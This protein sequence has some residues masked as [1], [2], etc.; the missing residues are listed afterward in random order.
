MPAS[1]DICERFWNLPSKPGEEA[2]RERLFLDDVI[3]KARLDREIASRRRGSEKSKSKMGLVVQRW[4]NALSRGQAFEDNGAVIE[5]QLDKLCEL[6]ATGFDG[7]DDLW[8]RHPQCGLWR[9]RL[10]QMWFLHAGADADHAARCPSD[11]LRFRRNTG[12]LP[13]LAHCRP[14]IAAASTRSS[15]KS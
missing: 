15:L 14:V 7:L 1:E 3:Q 12:G 9:A 10:N 4:H 11:R 13:M 2:R 8:R 6:K 5:W